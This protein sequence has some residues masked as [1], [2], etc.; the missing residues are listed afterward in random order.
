MCSKLWWNH[1]DQQTHIISIRTG[2]ELFLKKK[3]TVYIS[4]CDMHVLNSYNAHINMVS[5]LYECACV[6]SSQKPWQMIFQKVPL[7]RTSLLYEF[8]CAYSS[9]KTYKMI[10]H[11]VHMNMHSHLYEFA[12]VI[13]R[14]TCE[15]MSVYSLHIHRVSLLCECACEKSN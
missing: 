10:Y 8:S 14:L 7:D 1:N 13:Y 15:Q 4:R 3:I 12:C 11:N 5:H 6:P 9:H 2:Q